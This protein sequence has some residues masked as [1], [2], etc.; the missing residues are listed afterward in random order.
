M[1]KSTMKS[2]KHFAAAAMFLALASIISG[3]AQLTIDN[4]TVP[5]PTQSASD[6]GGGLA[7]DNKTGLGG[8]TISGERTITALRS[9]GTGTLQSRVDQS[10][11]T[12]N[13]DAGSGTTGEGSVEW[14]FAATDLTQGGATAFE[15]D[16]TNNDQGA[17]IT[18]EV[19]SASGTS[20]YTSGL[21]T[22]G[23]TGTFTAF[24]NQFSPTLTPHFTQAERIKIL[25]V[26]QSD[27]DFAMR[28]ILTKEPQDFGD[29][30][31]SGTS[32]N[33]SG[34]NSYCT[35]L[36][37]NGPRHIINTDVSGNITGP[38]L[39]TAVE[40]VDAEDDANT[41]S[42]A[43]GDDNAQNPADPFD[44]EAGVDGFNFLA[45]GTSSFDIHV[46]GATGKV[47]A[48]VDFNGD[49]DFAD[50]GEQ[51]LTNSSRIVGTHTITFTTPTDAFLG[52]TFMRVRISTADLTGSDTFKSTG[53]AASDGEVED[54]QITI[55]GFDWGDALDD[56]TV[57]GTIT[58]AYNTTSANTGAKHEI[59]SG[60]AFLGA[61]VDPE[62]DGNPTSG[63]DGD[64]V[65]DSPDDEDGVT[66]L[67]SVITTAGGSFPLT[68]TL[69]GGTNADVFAW[70]DISS[71]IAAFGGDG[72]FDNF[73]DQFLGTFGAAYNGGG[74]GTMNNVTGA[75][76]F[77]LN[78]PATGLVAGN[79]IFLRFRAVNTG[80]GVTDATG[81]VAN[82]E[83][84]D[85]VIQVVAQLQDWGDNP[86]T[87]TTTAGPRH[88]IVGTGPVF[89]N[90]RDAETAGQ[91]SA[92][93]NGDDTTDSPDDEDGVDFAS[94]GTIN[95]GSNISLP[96][97][98][99]QGTGLIN[100][101]IDFDGNGDYTGVGEQVLTNVSQGVGTSNHTISIPPTATAGT[102]HARFR[103]STAGS[104]AHNAGTAADG[105]IED[106]QITLTENLDFG[107]APESG[108]AP[109]GTGTNNYGTT[110]ANS[111]P[112][113]TIT[114][115]TLGA[116]V[117]AENDG[118]PN[119][120]ATGDGADE[121]GVTFPA[122]L[123]AGTIVQLPITVT[124]S[125]KITAWIDFNG[126]GDFDHP[127]ERVIDNDASGSGNYAIII[128]A[129]A[130]LGTTYARFRIVATTDPDITSPLGALD[131][132]EI[133]DYQ[134]TICADYGDAPASYCTDSTDP[135]PAS[136]ALDGP[137]LG[138]L[139]DSESDGQPNVS[140]TGDDIA[141]SAD[142]D[143]VSFTPAAGFD[144]NTAT[145]N[146][147]S[148]TV[149]DG[150]ADVEVFV[151]WNIDGDFEDANERY[152]FDTLASGPHTES[153]SVPVG[154]T[155]TGATYVRVRIY[156]EG[157][158][159]DSPCG[160]A[161]TGE[162]QDYQITISNTTFVDLLS[163]DAAVTDQ[164]RVAINWVTGAE[165]DTAGFN[166]LRR[167]LTD[168]TAASY[169]AAKVN[170]Q[171]IPSQGTS[172]E[173]ARYEYLD[174]PGYG[175]FLYQLEDVEVGGIASVHS[176]A[177]VT[178]NPELNISLMDNKQVG[179]E[180]LAIPG[181]SYAI[182]YRDGVDADGEWNELP[183]E[184]AETGKIIDEL[185]DDSTVRFYR[186]IANP[187]E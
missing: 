127:T 157:T 98:V 66:G 179:L 78:I 139:R 117:D 68:I 69:G 121:D 17:T 86:D 186:L 148:F 104:D 110:L 8:N 45:G 89:G 143:S 101:F 6:S 38:L 176:I 67:P 82:G 108:T 47:N 54:H 26:N 40:N 125:G 33:G 159:L 135:T 11:Q 128:P 18:I 28:A 146:S 138:T 56:G 97:T 42:T 115:P 15:F 120:S 10:G 154:A 155:S 75:Q 48:W 14:N 43:T 102:T 53:L 123:D 85:Y 16:V 27:T 114:G 91:P 64:D 73:G 61:S 175:T 131:S 145:S 52:D 158:S 185:S 3:Q 57:L 124:G 112:R 149:T 105:E 23:T 170:A 29:A 81:S 90:E 20:S 83:V 77:T 31:D 46:T 62:G 63:A 169:Q 34:T 19:E 162:V 5:T 160:H 173:G 181:W 24:F 103:I 71:G 37:N 30:P 1:V 144:L 172:V 187:V 174:T 118:Q 133:E 94:V 93:S 49:G 95:I 100:A 141:G 164:G 163:F 168:D 41:N 87:Y 161:E 96:I 13:V 109:S 113:H 80:T 88:N 136:H 58:T 166:I 156:T 134:V 137:R 177:E 44:D 7:T 142:E 107:D 22:A 76:A 65:T 126:D 21:I 70:A 167:Q 183:A 25:I 72:D 129:N 9:G 99:S 111:G 36:V 130:N 182:E 180:Y 140:A 51:V 39:G 151:D 116:S 84:E 74:G 122:C 171:L 2:R 106:Y 132:G 60:A 50:A 4:F 92:A 150:P 184:S 119:S 35:L 32:P 165:I 12:F 152:D 79:P 59:I 55:E 153:I 147:I 178:I